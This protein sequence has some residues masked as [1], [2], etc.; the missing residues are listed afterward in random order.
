M[1]GEILDW[2]TPPVATVSA[3][4]LAALVAGMFAV[5]QL[6][7]NGQ[8]QRSLEEQKAAAQ[9]DLEAY[10]S[11]LTI[12]QAR[13]E[14]ADQSAYQFRL[15]RLTPFID[16]LNR[17]VVHSYAAVVGLQL[18]TDLRG[19]LQ[20]LVQHGNSGMSDWLQ[21][22][23]DMSDL[24]IQM[25]LSI[26]DRSVI[27]FITEL[28]KFVGLQKSIME[29]RQAFLS[30]KATLQEVGSVHSEYVRAGYKLMMD[31]KNAITTAT[32]DREPLTPQQLSDLADSVAI[33]LERSSVGQRALWESTP[34]RMDRGL[35][36]ERRNSGIRS[37]RTRLRRF[38]QRSDRCR[39]CGPR[40]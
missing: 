2:L 3:G 30:Q 5:Y 28:Q 13:F 29:R 6:R 35:A 26:D 34:Q 36:G 39:A 12:L 40:S 4:V 24:R 18:F 16:A 11:E 15:E 38:R 10:K 31:V 1:R 32:L 7:K 21:A 17:S 9:R 23:Q 20:A 22:A 33:P 19:H 25:L 37:S 27:P 8:L 14:R